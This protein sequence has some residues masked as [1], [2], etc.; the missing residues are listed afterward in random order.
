MNSVHLNRTPFQRVGF[1]DLYPFVRGASVLDVGCK[2]GLICYEFAAHG[3]AA[4]HGIDRNEQFIGIARE[5]FFDISSC[6]HSF[7][8]ADALKLEWEF[9]RPAYADIVLMIATYHKL[10]RQD[11]NRAVE[12]IRVLGARAQQFFVWTGYSKELPE[13]ED[14]LGGAWRLTQTSNMNVPDE[15]IHT[16]W[17]RR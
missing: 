12:V 4:V 15:E 17:R 6:E 9:F 11:A 5:V 13:V 1:A 10:R 16:I 2:R 7:T 3:A 8:C 14:A